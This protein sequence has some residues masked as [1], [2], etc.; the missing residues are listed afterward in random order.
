MRNKLLLIAF[1]I[2]SISAKGQT[3]LDSLEAKVN[4]IELHLAKSQGYFRTAT[5]LTLA[6]TALILLAVPSLDH[7]QVKDPNFYRGVVAVG[8]ALVLSGG[9]VLTFSHKEI[10]IAGNWKK[11]EIKH[12]Y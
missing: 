12:S 5:G 7:K 8:S 10:G 11:K 9:I 4:N 6:G 1:A 3:R 2:M